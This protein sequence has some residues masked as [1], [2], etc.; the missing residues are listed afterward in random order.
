M[1]EA[2]ALDRQTLRVRWRASY[3]DAD[4]ITDDYPPLPRHILAEP[5]TQAVEARQFDAF[6]N[7]PYWNIEYVGAGP[8]KLDRW[9]PGSFIEAS[10]F[11]RHALGQAKIERIRLL[12]TSD[13][14]TVL[15]RLLAGELHAAID[16]SV[17]FQQG[18]VLRREWAHTKAGDIVINP[19]QWRYTYIQLRPDLAQ[20]RTLLD[21]RVRRAL[22][23]TLD[24]QGLNEGLFEGEGMMTETLIPPTV[25]Y[26]PALER[27]IARYPYDVRRAEQLMA[28]TGYVRGADGIFTHAVHGRFESEYKVLASVHNNTEAAILAAAWRQAGFD[29]AEATFSAAQGRDAHARATFTGMHTTSGSPLGEGRLVV[30][31]SSQIPTAENRWRGSN[32]SAWAN[33]EYDRLFDTYSTTLDRARRDQLVIEMMRVYTEELPALSLYFGLAVLPHSAALSGPGQVP[34]ETDVS[35]NVHEWTWR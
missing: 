23:H 27:A 14:N 15:A 4:R 11:D 34:P 19:T 2:L 35:W 24:R 13:A 17:R 6:V 7:H 26:F 18:L 31:H 20:P 25:S 9:E 21:L 32:R 28:E 8:F 12:F 5:F 22:A 30:L 29:I 3:P 16:D 1:E 33:P 10:A